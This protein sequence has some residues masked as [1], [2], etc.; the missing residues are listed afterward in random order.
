MTSAIS[1]VDK[2]WQ[3]SDTVEAFPT[4]GYTTN[5][6]DVSNDDSD[7]DGIIDAFDTTPGHGGDFTTPEDH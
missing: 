2:R 5:D 3:F 1:T 6:G 4:A 7:G